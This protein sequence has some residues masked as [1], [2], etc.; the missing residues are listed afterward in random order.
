MPRFLEKIKYGIIGLAFSAS[1]RV[2][3]ANWIIVIKSTPSGGLA[4]GHRNASGLAIGN[5]ADHCGRFTTYGE[6][7]ADRRCIPHLRLLKS[8]VTSKRDGVTQSRIANEDC[9]SSFALA[10]LSPCR[11]DRELCERRPNSGPR[12]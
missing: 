1:E 6:G 5:V 4:T 12:V 8:E 7:E 11:P 9:K 10:Y 2:P 3:E